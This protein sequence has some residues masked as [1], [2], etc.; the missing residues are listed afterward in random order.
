[1]VKFV[2]LSHPLVDGME[3]YPGLGNIEIGAHLDHEQS[4]PNYN[5]GAG[6][7]I[8]KISMITN[9]GTYLDSPFHRFPDGA[10]LSQVPLEKVA[11]LDGIVLDGK[12]SENSESGAALN[13]N[14]AKSVLKN[15]AVLI[16]T[17]WDKCWGETR[18]HK[19][20]PYLSMEFVELLVSAGAV[21]VGVDFLNVDNTNE[22]SR[23]VHTKLLYNDIL[24]V[25][26][27]RNLGS[28]PHTGFKFSAVP[29]RIVRGAS[30]P[31]RAFA[32][33]GN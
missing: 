13:F 17:G 10:D 28:L 9:A 12:V 5:D 2:E 27:L 7:Y 33:V 11:R 19:R 21:L 22:K 30:F 20:G 31:V 23:P 18:Y 6:F 29:L 4:R 24:I 3:A 26:N 8:G 1:M 32:E 25:E 16:R 14:V 15:K